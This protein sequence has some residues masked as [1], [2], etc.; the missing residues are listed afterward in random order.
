MK[1]I[2]CK[3]TV[4]AS[5]VLREVRLKLW[6]H[7]LLEKPEKF[8]MH[9]KIFHLNSHLAERTQENSPCLY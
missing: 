3:D 7:N 6:I 9:N 4:N 2:E 5:Q 8:V 1:Q